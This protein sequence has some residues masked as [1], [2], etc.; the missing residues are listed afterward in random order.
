M[1]N[2]ILVICPVDPSEEVDFV[3][4]CRENEYNAQEVGGEIST[5]KVGQYK[6]NYESMDIP[7]SARLDGNVAGNYCGSHSESKEDN[8]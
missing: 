4:S 8:P 6:F 2:G 5:A 1:K 3:L 7:C